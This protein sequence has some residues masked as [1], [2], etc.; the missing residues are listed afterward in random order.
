MHAITVTEGYIK[1]HDH[2]TLRVDASRRDQLR[3]LA[4][5]DAP[6]TVY[7]LPQPSRF[8]E[9]PTTFVIE[10]KGDRVYW[11]T[12][13]NWKAGEKPQDVANAEAPQAPLQL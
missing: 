3:A 11:K 4:L 7:Q 9:R 2:V 13:V 12:P 8:N 1:N 6:M 10:M 5:S